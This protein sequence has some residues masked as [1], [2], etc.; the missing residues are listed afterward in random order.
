MFNKVKE[1]RVLDFYA[2][3]SMG[4]EY[5]GR[6]QAAGCSLDISSKFAGIMDRSSQG[7]WQR[8]ERGGRSMYGGTG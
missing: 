7:I 5:H 6:E 4:Q 3:G 1:A 2:V 8:K